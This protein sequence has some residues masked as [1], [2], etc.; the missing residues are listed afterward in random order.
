MQPETRSKSMPLVQ[1]FPVPGRLLALAYRE[2]DMAA[3]G[4]DEQRAALGDISR[5]PRPWDPASCTTATLRV[6]IWRWLDAVVVWLNH[7]Y[8]FDPVDTIPACWPMHPHLVHEIA[9]LA[10]QRRRAAYTFTSDAMEE[11]HRYGL[12][13]FLER[14]H[15]RVADHCTEAHPGTWPASGRLNRHLGEQPVAARHRAFTN[16]VSALKCGESERSGSSRLR[17]VDE[18]TG[19]ILN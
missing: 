9:V 6:E 13:A 5:L 4:T 2:L 17:I 10:D 3:N 18:A 1:P 19:E 12:P 15:H 7:E 8:V 16:D 14:M 11:W